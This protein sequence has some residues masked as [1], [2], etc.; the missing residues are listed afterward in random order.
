M[1]SGVGDFCSHGISLDIFKLQELT[2]ERR[3]QGIID[4]EK[5]GVIGRN[6]GSCHIEMSFVCKLLTK[7]Y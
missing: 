6:P 7:C 5:E 3:K 2:I 4:A 1:E